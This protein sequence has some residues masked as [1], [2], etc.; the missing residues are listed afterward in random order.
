VGL[1]NGLAGVRVL[2]HAVVVNNLAL[3][4]S[5]LSLHVEGLHALLLLTIIHAILKPAQRIVSWV[6]GKAGVRVQ[7]RAE[8]ER[9]IALALS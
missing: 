2:S 1:V 8:V 7:N 6:N 3:V 9:Y 5:R 4:L